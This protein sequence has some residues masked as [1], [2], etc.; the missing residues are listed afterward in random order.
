[1]QIDIVKRKPG[2]FRH[3]G[4]GSDPVETGRVDRLRLTGASEGAGTARLYGRFRIGGQVIW[5]TNYE[6]VRTKET[7]GGLGKGAPK[8]TTVTYEYFANFAV[9]LAEGLLR[10]RGAAA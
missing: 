9:A 3:F 8:Q 5:A 10:A 7:Q 6:E 2:F 4:A 1:M